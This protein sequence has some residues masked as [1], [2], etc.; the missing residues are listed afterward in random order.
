M[1]INGVDITGIS[2]DS[3]KVQVGDLYVCI[4]GLHVDGHD[5]A[6]SAVEAGAVAVLCKTGR[7]G[8]MPQNAAAISADDTRLAMAHICHEFFGDPA[9]GMKLIGITG[10]NGKTSTTAFLEGILRKCGKRVGSIGTLGVL[11]DGKPL[12]M[13]FATSTTPDTVELYQILGVMAGAGAEYVVMEVSSHALALHKVAALTFEL[14]LFTNLTQDHLDFHGTMEN[15][16]LAKAGLFD[17]C[18]TGIINHDDDTRD[19]LL[20]YAKCKMFTY[21]IDGGDYRAEDCVLQSFGI[22]YIIKGQ[23]VDVPIPG[24]FTVYNSLCAYGAS[25]QLGL[26]HEEVAAALRGVRG[27]GG[28]IQSISNNRGFSV[29]VDYAHSPDGLEN[30]ISACREFTKGRIIT[31]FG[32]GGDRDAVK[33]PI[34]GEIAGRLSDLVIITSDNPRNESPEAIIDEIAGGIAG[35]ARNDGVCA[36]GIAGGARND[37]V[38]SVGAGIVRP[39]SDIYKIT[40]RGEAITKAINL[41]KPDD[42]IIIAG[43]GHENYQE[44]EN[45]R[46]EHFDDAEF[47]RNILGEDE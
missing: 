31:V 24:K 11:L 42:C 37:G 45:G 44:F 4:E 27:V 34:M 18:K 29:I 35:Q 28:R 25:I 1:R 32:C 30:I 3:R 14:G 33:R 2:I 39:Q 36:D 10:T 38:C 21:G 13:P 12:D 46:R 7:E 41:A 23:G 26:A 20:D 16:R 40:H 22:S 19:F 15:Y 17:L 43:K 6:Q 8:D 9:K 5:F 47:V